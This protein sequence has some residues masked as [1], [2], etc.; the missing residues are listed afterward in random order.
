[1]L[2]CLYWR[3]QLLKKF[4]L[5]NIPYLADI[6]SMLNLLHSLGVN[7]KFTDKSTKNTIY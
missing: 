4:Q 6:N 3:H 5:T 2:R 1:M 7:Y